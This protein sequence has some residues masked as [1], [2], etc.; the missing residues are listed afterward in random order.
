M[1]DLFAPM[2]E[3]E[4]DESDE[5]LSEDDE[6][7]DRSTLA[8]SA[9]F[10]DDDVDDALFKQMKLVERQS[11]RNPKYSYGKLSSQ[12]VAARDAM[13]R[14][15]DAGFIKL[16]VL[17][18]KNER[19]A[20]HGS[21]GGSTLLHHACSYG[22]RNCVKILLKAGADRYLPDRRGVIPQNIARA[23]GELK[24]ALLVEFWDSPSWQSE[25]QVENS[26]FDFDP[27][28]AAAR[29]EQ[30]RIETVTEQ[31]KKAAEEHRV[32]TRERNAKNYGINK[33]DLTP[34]PG[35]KGRKKV[36][37][38]DVIDPAHL[39]ILPPGPGISSHSH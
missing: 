29:A 30:E 26:N 38:P 11:W 6:D 3:E 10:S 12:W 17:I 22:C 4:E 39:S 32:K 7:E 21:W 9:G 16:Q 5:E 2:A 36:A 28:R 1:P 25:T 37:P 20:S 35:K 24:I 27:E 23:K 8:E 13:R 33:P 18:K 14:S 15:D 31:R 19:E 34:I